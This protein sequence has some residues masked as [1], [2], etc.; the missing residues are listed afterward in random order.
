MVMVI[1]YIIYV[2]AVKGTDA[3]YREMATKVRE[4]GLVIAGLTDTDA[5][6]ETFHACQLRS[7]G[8]S[9]NSAIRNNLKKREICHLRDFKIAALVSY[10][11]I[12]SDLL[13]HLIFTFLY[14]HAQGA[15]M[16]CMLTF[17]TIPYYICCCLRKQQFDALVFPVNQEEDSERLDP[18]TA[19]ALPVVEELE[20]DDSRKGSDS[21]VTGLIIETPLSKDNIPPAKAPS[22][23]PTPVKK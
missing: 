2:D 1:A 3:S 17:T 9:L 15:A 22:P 19:D 11:W 8:V 21:S 10:Q 14:A 4:L 5:I 7:I 20:Y 16:I 13:C 12:R 23:S 18:T 6:P